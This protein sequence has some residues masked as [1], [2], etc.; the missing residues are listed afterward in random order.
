MKKNMNKSNQSDD[1]VKF[2]D[3]EYLVEDLEYL[4]FKAELFLHVDQKQIDDMKS[5]FD[6]LKRSEKISKEQK[7]DG[8][9]FALVGGVTIYKTD[10]KKLL[11]VLDIWQKEL[12]Y[13]E[14]LPTKFVVIEN[15]FTD[16]HKRILAKLPLVN[17]NGMSFVS[18]I[19]NRFYKV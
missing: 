6:G 13:L 11:S 12:S 9:S 8:F 18:E 5:I 10:K 17:D 16:F 15:N 7:L 19:S 1:K 3:S 14:I 2:Q 4:E